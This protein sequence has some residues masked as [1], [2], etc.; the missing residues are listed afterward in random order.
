MAVVSSSAYTWWPTS[1]QEVSSSKLAGYVGHGE[2]CPAGSITVSQVRG[3]RSCLV[4]SGTCIWDMCMGQQKR[5]CL[6]R[7]YI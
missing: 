1:E 6:P 2:E 7:P 4:G 3:V 5:C